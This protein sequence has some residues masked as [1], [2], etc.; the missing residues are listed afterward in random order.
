LYD[1][2]GI[3]L[4]FALPIYK[5]LCDML[6][7]KPLLCKSEIMTKYSSDDIKSRSGLEL[8]RERPELYWGPHGPSENAAASKLVDQLMIL[9]C[10]DIR[11]IKIDDW[12]VVG[13]EKD[14]VSSVLIESTLELLFTS[15]IPFKES[16]YLNS[17]RSEIL[18]YDF[19]KDIA[20]LRCGQIIEIKG[21]CENIDVNSIRN[22]L[23]GTALFY[24]GSSYA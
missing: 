13:A 4:L 20:L 12:C 14:W 10:D 3:F 6:S 9:G 15:I 1:L 17:I 23:N 24:R 22:I 19:A 2:K 16:K 8:V 18:I 11:V 21:N 7:H 5:G